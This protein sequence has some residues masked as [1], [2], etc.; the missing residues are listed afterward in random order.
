MPLIT[1]PPTVTK[2]D[3][4]I[5]P[6]QTGWRGG[7]VVGWP[8]VRQR[9]DV[10]ERPLPARHVYFCLIYFFFLI[11][12]VG[13]DGRAM[14]A[15]DLSKA[16]LLRSRAQTGEF[17]YPPCIRLQPV[18]APGGDAYIC[19]HACVCASCVCASC[20]CVRARV[21]ACAYVTMCVSVFFAI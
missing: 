14:G 4:I 17:P 20:A 11:T 5:A 19:A 2:L 21:Y 10:T 15:S 16:K 12:K 7:G 6:Q 18:M 13:R 3:K 1:N 9:G 8:V